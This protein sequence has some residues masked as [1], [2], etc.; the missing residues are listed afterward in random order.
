MLQSNKAEV[1]GLGRSYELGNT[2]LRYGGNE[3]EM[4]DCL[5]MFVD[6]LSFNIGTGGI[7][8]FAS[9]FANPSSCFSLM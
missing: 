6:A 7:V 1:G 8:Y 3:K 2:E 5:P 9:S 4:S